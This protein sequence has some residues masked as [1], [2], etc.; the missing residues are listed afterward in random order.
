MSGTSGKRPRPNGPPP[1]RGPRRGPGPRR[2]ASDTGARKSPRASGRR[3]REA[4]PPGPP[5]DPSESAS[6]VDLKELRSALRDPRHKGFRGKRFSRYDIH[7]EIARGG[8][9]IVLRAKHRELE[10]LVALKLLASDDPSPEALARFRREARVLARIKHNHVVGISDLGEENGVAFLAMELIDGGTLQDHVDGVLERGER[11]EVERA[12]EIILAM[13]QALSHCHE[14][15]AIHRDVKP[16]NILLERETGR[17][18]LTDF[19]LV[20]RDRNKMG[21]SSSISG[22]I[23]QTGK[24]LGTPSYMSPEQFEPEGEFGSVGPK[25]DVWALG[26]VL[27]F[28]LTGQPPFASR[29]VVDLYGQVTGDPAPTA[30]ELREDVPPALDELIQACLAK[31]VDER[32]SM[33]DL[34]ARLEA[35]V[36]DPKLLRPRGG[37]GARHALAVIVLFFMLALVHLTLISPKQGERLLI[38]MGLREAP[39]PQDE[40]ASLSE[41]AER[42]DVE[43]LLELAERVE[44]KEPQ[45]AQELLERAA[46]AESPRAMV[47]L[48]VA[49]QAKKTQ[50]DDLEAYRWFRKA[51]DAK[52]HEAMLWVGLLVAEG[53]GVKAA[54]P[55]IALQWLARAEGSAGGRQASRGRPGQGARR[56]PRVG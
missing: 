6:S 46:Q 19:G 47:R 53:R 35:L 22:A 38:M 44:A 15:G 7:E 11:V 52:D 3:P 17:P 25:S 43:A 29:N 4:G 23:S 18:V 45:R 54:E 10:A 49:L 20:K 31:Q 55:A 30:S 39:E 16:H 37:S 41:R 36:A 5:G 27:F 1:G 28:T 32:I 13:A 33:A 56:A 51:A 50:A 42:G 48:G 21:Q 2:S 34:V 24:I 9:G 26:A 12:V 40:L 14:V 8:M